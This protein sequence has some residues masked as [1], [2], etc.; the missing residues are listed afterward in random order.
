MSHLPF[1][2]LQQRNYRKLR[3]IR[4]HQTRCDLF[5]FSPWC[6]TT[7]ATL[8]L[9]FG[10]QVISSEPKKQHRAKK[11]NDKKLI[12]Q[13]NDV[14][15]SEVADT[16]YQFTLQLTSAF[17]LNLCYP[18]FLLNVQCERN[19]YTTDCW[20]QFYW[21][22]VYYDVAFVPLHFNHRVLH[23]FLKRKINTH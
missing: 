23:H 21:Y 20:S 15:W 1:F 18:W 12:E 19:Y 14:K 8:N 5:W 7:T 3:S 22:V 9:L 13:T 17:P 4:S 2:L 11:W 10:G 6:V 16:L